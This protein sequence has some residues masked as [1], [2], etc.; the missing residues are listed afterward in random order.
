MTW[1]EPSKAIKDFSEISGMIGNAEVRNWQDRK[2][3]VV[4]YF[5]S[6]S[7]QEIVM[8][9]GMLPFRMRGTGSSGTEL[10]DAFFSEVCCTFPR[11]CFNQ[12]L[13]GEYG[14]LDGLI[15]TN[16]CDHL[17]HTYENWKNADIGTPFLHMLFRPSRCGEEMAGLYRDNLAILKD[18][19]E[20]HF[21]VDISDQD[22][23]NAIRLS[24]RTRK[25]QRELYE[26]R[27]AESPPIT[28]AET[29]SVM[30]AGT[31]MPRELYNERLESL[32][33]AL[34]GSER[35]M[36]EGSA[37]RLMVIGACNDD[38][39][40]CNLIE[41]SG[42]IVVVDETCFGSRNIWQDM[43]EG[44]SDPLGAIAKYYV[45]E[46][47]SCP[48]ILGDHDR[49]ADWIIDAARA[50]GV[51]GVVGQALV[52]CDMY[53]SEFYMLKPKLRDAGIPFL[54]IDA[55]YVPAF[56]GQLRTRVQAFIETLG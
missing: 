1:I 13:N 34:D 2:G 31:A 6:F 21:E 7:P 10:A 48:R 15:V 5:C 39:H 25:L 50:F 36:D 33:S 24:N 9:A 29:V 45:N 44:G 51:D 14:F 26:L 16:G 22:L 54:Q 52:A 18:E 55:E 20:K 27:K 8:A 17:R 32:L 37:A 49:R 53:A 46:R 35:R 43:D 19:L 56:T 11:H 23:L 47:P 30:V 3:K 28:G 38:P 4:G 41:E 12:A 40:V 42:G